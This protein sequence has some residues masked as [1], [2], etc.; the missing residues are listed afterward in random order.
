MFRTIAARSAQLHTPFQSWIF[1]SG[2]DAG[3]DATYLHSPNPNAQNF[4]L[5][6]P[7]LRFD[8]RAT[9]QVAAR[10]DPLF[11]G[12]RVGELCYPDP[13]GSGR[14][15]RDFFVVSDRVGL[16]LGP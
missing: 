13:E 11:P 7:D 4:P 15:V 12:I 3:Y 2:L 5:S 9:L 16:P 14:T 1:L 6:L 8:S 10:L